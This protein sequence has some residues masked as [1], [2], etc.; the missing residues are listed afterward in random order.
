MARYRS[1]PKKRRAK[2]GKAAWTEFTCPECSAENP[3]DDG[4]AAGD[5]V[6]CSWCGAVFR[7][8]S[9]PDSDPPR[10]RLELE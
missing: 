7:V 4:F 1:E 3:W 8:R 10:Y 5:E 2:G 6:F 9:I